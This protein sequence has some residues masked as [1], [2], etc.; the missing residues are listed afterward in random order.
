MKWY[1]TIFKKIEFCEIE[2]FTESSVWIPTTD[3]RRQVQ[4]SRRSRITDFECYFPSFGE[5]KEHLVKVYRQE[6]D[7]ADKK[8]KARQDD[9]KLILAITEDKIK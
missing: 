4:L 9:L 5:A 7:S 2:K 3:M 6:M 1:K 8:L